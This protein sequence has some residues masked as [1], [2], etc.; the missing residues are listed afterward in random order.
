MQLGV[1]RNWH[2]SCTLL[3]TEVYVAVSNPTNDKTVIR[4]SKDLWETKDSR[5]R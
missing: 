1:N 4:G 5:E 3:I 2:D